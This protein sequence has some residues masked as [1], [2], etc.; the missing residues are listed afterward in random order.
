VKPDKVLKIKS[1]EDNV[2]HTIYLWTTPLKKVKVDAAV[3]EE[4]EEEE[5]P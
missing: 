2:E 5:D 4:E 1:K 3:A